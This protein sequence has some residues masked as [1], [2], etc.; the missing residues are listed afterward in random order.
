MKNV[1]MS[2]FMLFTVQDGMM[3]SNRVL[4]IG[5]H[6]RVHDTPRLPVRNLTHH[7]TLHGM[8]LICKMNLDM[9]I[10]DHYFHRAGENNIFVR[11]YE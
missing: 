11:P 9:M 6:D 8:S 10:K 4:K 3:S 1:S 5:D 2:I 7:C